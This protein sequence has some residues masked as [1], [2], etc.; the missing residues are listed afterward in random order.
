MNVCNLV[1]LNDFAGHE[2]VLEYHITQH[3]MTKMI[4]QAYII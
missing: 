4:S 1:V 2:S 3:V